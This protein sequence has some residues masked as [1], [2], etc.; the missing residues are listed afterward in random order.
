MLYSKKGKNVNIEVNGKLFC[1]YNKYISELGEFPFKYINLENIY[2]DPCLDSF[3]IDNLNL[4]ELKE[5]KLYIFKKVEE[6]KSFTKKY[7]TIY[8][9]YKEKYINNDN[10]ENEIIELKE[11]NEML[12]F[13]LKCHDMKFKINDEK[14]DFD[15]IISKITF[16]F[17]RAEIYQINELIE[18]LTE[19]KIEN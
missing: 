15:K 3:I 4:K 2:K 16:D 9:N 14:G 8:D 6:I 18:K 5:I 7:N 10:L 13:L 11:K 1:L 12:K 19:I 17:L